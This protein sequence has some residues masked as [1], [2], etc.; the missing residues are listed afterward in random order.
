MDSMQ[1]SI[2]PSLPWKGKASNKAKRSLIPLARSKGLRFFCGQKRSKSAF[3][4]K[5]IAN[6]GKAHEFTGKEI[7]YGME[8]TGF[9]L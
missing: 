9:E 5:N 4:I 1:D 7:H 6:Y 8:P 2:I 3:L